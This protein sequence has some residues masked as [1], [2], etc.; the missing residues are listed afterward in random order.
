MDVLKGTVFESPFQYNL[1]VNV[2]PNG[3]PHTINGKGL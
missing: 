1:D 2:Y 3:S